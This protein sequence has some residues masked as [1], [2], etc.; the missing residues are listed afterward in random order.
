MMQNW[1]WGIQKSGR[2]TNLDKHMSKLI[3]DV[4]N[5]DTQNDIQNDKYFRME[6]IG[7]NLT[8]IDREKS[9][10]NGCTND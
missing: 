1:T 10:A 3:E 6:G 5:L 8:P 2:R 4:M 9:E 7:P